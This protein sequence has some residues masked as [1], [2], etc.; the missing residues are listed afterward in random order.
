[1]WAAESA[2]Q[3]REDV[4]YEVNRTRSNKKEKDAARINIPKGT[5]RNCAVPAT[6]TVFHRQ[7][8]PAG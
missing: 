3:E 8:F 6:F 7:S 5:S 2:P 4:L 1:M